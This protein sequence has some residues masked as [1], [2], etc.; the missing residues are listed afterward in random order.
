VGPYPVR[1]HGEDR[2]GRDG[3]ASDPVPPG[4]AGSRCYARQ[5]IEVEGDRPY[6]EA[7]AS[8]EALGAVVGGV[9][10]YRGSLRAPLSGPHEECP[11]ELLANAA[12]AMGWIDVNAL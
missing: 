1:A 9:C 5:I 10:G 3:A 4:L 7:V 8:I 2:V 6:G 12:A 11:H